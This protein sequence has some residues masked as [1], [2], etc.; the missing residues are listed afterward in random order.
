[1]TFGTETKTEGG[2]LVNDNSNKGN[3]NNN[4]DSGVHKGI[5][6]AEKM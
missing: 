3:W 5:S 2:E 6:I 1:L 4:D